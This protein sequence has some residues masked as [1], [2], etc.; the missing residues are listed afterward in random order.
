MSFSGVT[1]KTNNSGTYQQS[2]ITEKKKENSDL[3]N[4]F[5][6]N[7]EWNEGDIKI[8]P[9]TIERVTVSPKI[10]VEE[11]LSQVGESLQE[12]TEEKITHLA[13]CLTALAS[14][15]KIPLQDLINYDPGLLLKRLGTAYFTSTLADSDQKLLEGANVLKIKI[16][17]VVK[18]FDKQLEKV[19]KNK[20]LM[21]KVFHLL[22][23]QK[24]ILQNLNTTKFYTDDD[25]NFFVKWLNDLAVDSFT[26]DNELFLKEWMNGTVKTPFSEGDQAFLNKI[27]KV[28]FKT[29]YG[30]FQDD[31]KIFHSKFKAL[32]IDAAEVRKALDDL[33][34]TL[35]KR[36]K[37]DK[38]LLFSQENQGAILNTAEARYGINIAKDQQDLHER[39]SNFSKLLAEMEHSLFTMEQETIWWFKFYFS[40][41]AYCS[42]HHYDPNGTFVESSFRISYKSGYYKYAEEDSLKFDNKGIVIPIDQAYKAENLDATI[43]NFTGSQLVINEKTK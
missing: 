33:K 17:Q 18:D 39:T 13:A 30:D 19:Q 2:N 5:E 20:N 27:L 10:E 3:A 8:I 16:T 9:I 22:D 12:L 24:T 21:S 23:F 35:E 36:I 15:A 31:F 43:N 32:S 25:I 28:P 34:L 37:K 14:K 41:G 29:I 38:S 1:E 4:I 7:T 26:L 11:K 6:S 40:F 42:A